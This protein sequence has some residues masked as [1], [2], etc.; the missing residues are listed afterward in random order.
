[1]EQETNV[2]SGKTIDEAIFIGLQT[3]GVS[4]DEVEITTVQHES[5]GLFGIGAKKA[6]VRLTRRET[7]VVPVFEK[8]EDRP[9][10]D[11]PREDRL[12]SDRPREDRPKSDRPREDRP[13]SDRPREDRPEAINAE[14]EQE[15]PED[16][17]A[18]PREWGGI[19]YSRELADSDPDAQFLSGMLEA[20]QLKCSVLAAETD[21]GLKLIIESD[22]DG[23]L[24]GRHGE[25]LDAIQYIV[26][27]HANRHRKEAGPRRISIDTEGYRVRREETLRKLARRNAARVVKTGRSMAMEPMNPYERRVLHYALQNFRGVTTHSEGEEPN[28][29]VIIT[30]TKK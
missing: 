28:R 7:P 11:R 13:K 26:S 30:P 20:M 4:L 1:M 3:M 24:I 29:R 15:L 21:D 6:L 5:K 19:E 17:N 2:F 22:T 25:T 14:P 10:S 16:E 8:R 9:K 18:L 27:H 12:K 23:L